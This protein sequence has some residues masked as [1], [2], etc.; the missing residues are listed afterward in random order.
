MAPPSKSSGSKSRSSKKKGSASKSRSSSPARKA[1]GAAKKSKSTARKSKSTVREARPRV[2]NPAD[3]GANAA[4]AAAAA[5]KGTKAASH[6]VA[7]V[8]TRAKKPLIVGGA[9]VA[10]V[11]GGIALRHRGGAGRR[12]LPFGLQMRNGNLDLS[13]IASGAQ[14][15]GQIGQQI[16]ELAAAADRA[17]GG[18]SKR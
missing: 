12:R 17:S 4:A 10:G 9:A 13:S 5:A 1:S 18:K 14:R 11:A 15:V 6:A 16:S 7:A 8:A 3:R 2:P